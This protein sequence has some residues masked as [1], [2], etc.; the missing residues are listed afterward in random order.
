MV[1]GLMRSEAAGISSV[2]KV[3]K[4]IAELLRHVTKVDI[5][6]VVVVRAVSRASIEMRSLNEGFF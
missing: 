4:S 6:I 2:K 3:T 5:T 1:S